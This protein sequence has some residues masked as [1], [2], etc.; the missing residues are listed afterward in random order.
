MR[1]WIS[2]LSL[3]CLVCLASTLNAADRFAEWRGNDGQGHSNAV[4][5]PVKWSETRNVAWKTTIPGSGWSTPVVENGVVWVTTAI[6]EPANKDEFERRRKAS[7]NKQPLRISDSVS[8]RAVGV[9]LATGK[10]VRDVELLSEEKPQQIHYVN[11]YASPSPVI[12]DGRLYCHYGTYGIACLDVKSGEVLWRNKD[13]RVEHENGPGSSPILWQDRLIIHCDGID[14]QY[15]VALNKDTGKE[16]W[17]TDRTGQLRDNV[18]L[19]KSYATALIVQVEGKPL[20]VSPAADWLYGYDPQ[21]GR[22]LW[23]M[24]YGELGFSN[25][26]RPIQGHG[27]VYVCTGYMKSQLMALKLHLDKPPTV[28]WRFKKQVPN[29]GSPLMVG[30]QIY[31]AS[32]NG[33]ATCID[34]ISGESRWVQRI[35]KKFWASPLY[36]DGKIYFF[37]STGDTTVIAPSTDF[38]RLSINKLEGTLYAAGSAVDGA[39]LIRTSEGLYCFANARK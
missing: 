18:Q 2:V 5:L 29:V 31:F 14:K 28:A 4:N 24:S 9:D 38:R 22:E 30:K 26:G 25:A 32:D 7:T 11:T 12:E 20:V 15:I 3:T 6:D 35:G 36:A 37:D 1:S 19:R 13:M 34:A 17:R 27:M 8:L 21:S 16:V 10:I 33:I 23:K 39:M